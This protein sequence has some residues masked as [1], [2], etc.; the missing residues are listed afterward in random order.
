MNAATC[1]HGL[2][3]RDGQRMITAH[4][5]NAGTR[6]PLRHIVKHS[7]T[8]MEWG[9][10]GSGPADLA[11]SLLIDALGPAAVCPVCAG[12]RR[13]VWQ[14]DGQEVPYDPATAGPGAEVLGC[15]ACD[16]GYRQ[17]PYQD[18]KFLV[19][20]GFKHDAWRIERADII[21]WLLDNGCDVAGWLAAVPTSTGWLA[22]AR[23]V[24]EEPPP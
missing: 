14:P 21:G 15:I 12:T 20:A 6:E 17:L 13:V 4:D 9:Y 19:V 16:R 11:R 24:A 7:P 5:K 23:A 8:G 18:F 1:Y 2:R 3:T 10:S 22:I